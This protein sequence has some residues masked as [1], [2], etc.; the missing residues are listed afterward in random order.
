MDP[1]GD[2]Q[3]NNVLFV[4]QAWREKQ[5]EADFWRKALT[6]EVREAKQ[7]GHSYQQL[8]DAVGVSISVIQRMVR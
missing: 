7:A 4:A 3:I 2:L 1:I 6:K 5:E 8:A